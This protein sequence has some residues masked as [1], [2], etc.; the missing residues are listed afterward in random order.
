MGWALLNG[1]RQI[2]L[3]RLSYIPLYVSKIYDFFAADLN[4]P[5]ASKPENAW[6]EFEGVPLKWYRRLG[7][8]QASRKLTPRLQALARWGSIRSV[9]RAGSLAADE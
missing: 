2:L 5:S 1:G 4:D 7:A 8:L 9:Y 6:L 3:P